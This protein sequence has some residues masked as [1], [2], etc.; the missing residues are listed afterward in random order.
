MEL[1]KIAIITELIDE[2]LNN[3][4]TNY[5]VVSKFLPR[6]ILSA[7]DPISIGEK[8]T[9]GK[10][11]QTIFQT[12]DLENR[13]GNRNRLQTSELQFTKQ[14]NKLF[15]FVNQVSEKLKQR[16]TLSPMKILVSKPG[17]LEQAFHQDH[18]PTTVNVGLS[19]SSII[20]IQTGTSLQILEKN[21]STRTV[22]L[23]PG[24]A[25]FFKGTCIH[26]GS[27]YSEMNSRIHFFLDVDHTRKDGFTYYK[28]LLG[29]YNALSYLE[30]RIIHLHSKIKNKKKLKK[31]IGR[32][33]F[34]AKIKHLV[35]FKI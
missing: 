31:N 28:D 4:S 26:A 15:L 20:S 1:S 33:L 3:E 25:I 6:Q 10:K 29:A 2:S 13:F 30:Q 5:L 11:Y 34:D 7:I 8:I 27:A 24:D 23:D 35:S 32:R 12:T 19:L 9:R 17:C 22:R 14:F 16:R 21:G 18:D